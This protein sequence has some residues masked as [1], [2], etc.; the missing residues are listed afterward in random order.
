M[1]QAE[2]IE[3]ADGLRELQAV[4]VPDPRTHRNELLAD[5][6]ARIAQ[7]QLIES[8]PHAVRVHFETAK[9]LYLYAWFVYRFHTVAETHAFAT[10]EFA[11]R[12]KLTFLFPDE[13]GPDAK[14]H[15]TLRSLFARARKE[16]LIANSGLRAAQRLPYER[17]RYRAS[18]ERGREMLAR[19]LTEIVYDDSDIQPLPEDFAVDALEVFQSTMPRIRNIHAHGSSMLYP[20]V[21]HTFE[22]V[23]DLINQLFPVPASDAQR[24]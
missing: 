20:T 19:G 17:A 1:T 16:G 13:F 23:T 6:Q 18:I 15:P 5:R 10:L 22:V 14:R 3:P 2:G 9:N 11:L 24:L 21:L 7:Y 4:L 12:E 8:V